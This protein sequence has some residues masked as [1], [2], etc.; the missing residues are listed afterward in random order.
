MEFLSSPLRLARTCL[1]LSSAEEYSLLY[2]LNTR[3][4]SLLAPALNMHPGAKYSARTRLWQGIPGIERTKNGKLVATWYSGGE[5]EGPENYILLAKSE[6][7]GETWSDPFAVIDPPSPVRAFDPVLWSDPEGTLWWFWSQSYGLFDGRMGVWAICCND[8]DAREMQWSTPKR[9][10]DGIMMN[11]PTVL[12]SGV[13]LIPAAIWSNLESGEIFGEEIVKLQRSNTYASD[14]K[15]VNW[16]LLGQADVPN[17]HFDEHMIVERCDA[18]LWMLVRTYSGIG[19]AISND[20]GK[21]W[22]ATQGDVLPGPCS[23]FFIRR[24]QS[25]KLLMVNHH[26]FQG[27]NNLT[28]SLSDDDGRNWFG[29]LMLDERPDV[30]Y[31]DGIESPDGIIYVIYDRERTKAREILLA[32]FTE[33]DVECGKPSSG[34]C[35]LKWIINR[36]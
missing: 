28:A 15:G 5:N 10:F 18:S 3:D 25:G 2:P 20:A 24:L 9:L 19:Q 12:N 22:F 7:D 29:F 30:S 35:R 6:D 16:K 8:P 34:I 1:D 31:P 27:R 33:K 32:R 23:R 4:L 13:W 17:R 26:Q 14:D 11:K 36:V 21:T